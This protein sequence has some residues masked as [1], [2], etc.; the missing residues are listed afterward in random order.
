[1]YKRLLIALLVLWV[2]TVQAQNMDK[3][4][5]KGNRN[6][7]SGDYTE[8]EVYYRKVIDASPT[9]ADAHFNLGDA[10]FQQENYDGALKA[11]QKVLEVSPDA[12]LKSKAVFNMGACM[13][14]QEKYYD[15][16]ELYKV[17]LKLDE[18]NEDALYNLEY[19]RA[20]LVKSRVWVLPNI[21]HGTVTAREKTAYNGQMVNLSSEP[22]EDYG[23]ANYI[24]VKA[25]DTQVTV[26]V[27][28]SRFEMPKFDVLVSAEFK[29]MHRISIDPNIA[30]GTVSTDRQKAIEG[31]SVT[32]YSNPDPKYMVDRYIAYR[33][34]NPKDTL[35]VQDTVFQMPDFDVTVSARFRTALTITVDSTANGTVRVTDSLALPGQNIGIIVKPNPG[36]QLDELTVVSDVDPSTTVPV[37]DMNLFQMIDSDVTVKAV[38]G[39]ARETYKVQTDSLIEGGHVLTDVPQATRGETVMLKNVPDPDY[40]FKEYVITQLGDTSVHVQPLGNFFTMPGFDVMVSAVFEKQEGQDQQQQQ[41]QQQQEEQEQE[42]QDQQQQ[43][44]QQQDQ[45]NQ[46]QQQNPQ[47]M[48]KDD[49]Q[50]MLDALENQEKKTM[51]KVNEQKVRNQSKRKAEKDW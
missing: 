26:P 11:F 39:E 49:A 45:Q 38:F 51:E 37:S 19:C 33:T 12:K 47:E 21:P 23:L 50:R 5:R 25:D 43:Q 28:G 17:A 8:A 36:Y 7:K 32:M 6:Y 34:G 16:F 10:L 9:N 48:S 18:N 31:Q 13:M 41:Q 40:K 20:H 3:M 1:M 46:Q 30:H 15:A 42:E 24:V 44:Q 4:I 2:A 27:S 22:E 29:K 14:A 35:A